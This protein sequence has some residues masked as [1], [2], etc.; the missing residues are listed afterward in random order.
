[1][2][3]SGRF[4][5]DLILLSVQGDQLLFLCSNTL[6]TSLTCLTH[7][8]TTGLG[9]VGEHLAALLLSLLLVNVFHEDALV[10]EH[11]TLALHV[12]IVVQMTIDLLAVAILLQQAT[13]HT[14][15]LHPQQLGGHTSICCTLALT[16]ATVTALTACFGV[17]A[18]TVAGMHHDG[19][20]DDQTIL[21]QFAYVLTCK[22][23]YPFGILV[24]TQASF[25]FCILTRVCVGDFIDFIRIQPNLLLAATQ[26]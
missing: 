19:L 17:L 18:H 7:L 11:I 16:K 4:R 12:Q 14:L 1:M 25:S 21:D 9:L 23:K 22:A 2:T 8:L 20:L 13:Q 24:H 15:P 6:L 10:L 26:H 5:S 3:R